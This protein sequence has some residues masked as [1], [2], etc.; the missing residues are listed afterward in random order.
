MKFDPTNH[1]PDPAYLRGLIEK[2]ELSQ[3]KIAALLG[4]DER[5]FRMYLANRKAKNILDC[6]YV[7]QFCL[8][9]LAEEKVQSVGQ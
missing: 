7:V 8:E 6:P 9:W 4:I 5:T 2:I 1:N 3:R